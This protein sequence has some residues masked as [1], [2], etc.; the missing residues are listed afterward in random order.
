MT[1]GNPSN[2]NN[3]QI[4]SCVSQSAN[5][6]WDYDIV[7][8]ERKGGRGSVL[9]CLF[10][11]GDIVSFGRTVTNVRILQREVLPT[12]LAYVVFFSF[13]S[14]LSHTIPQP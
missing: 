7:S 1:D 5:Q 3:L 14:F 12:E 2:G 6:L 4:W 9:T 13:L 8:C 11:S 10:C